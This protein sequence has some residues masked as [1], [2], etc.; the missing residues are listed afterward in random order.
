M[1]KVLSEDSMLESGDLLP[2][3]SYNAHAAHRVEL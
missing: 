1:S 2:S 3:I